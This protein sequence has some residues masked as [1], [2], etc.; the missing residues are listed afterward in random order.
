M[1][2]RVYFVPHFLV[3]LEMVH[4]NSWLPRSY[5]FLYFSCCPHSLEAKVFVAIIQMLLFRW[6]M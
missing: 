1:L 6:M 3:A 2:T 4:L 5:V